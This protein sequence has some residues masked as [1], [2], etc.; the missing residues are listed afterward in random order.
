MTDAARGGDD[1]LSGGDQSDALYGDAQFMSGGTRG[2]DDRLD[3]GPG[4]DFLVGDAQVL[5]FTLQV[6][7]PEDLFGVPRIVFA[8]PQGGRDTFAGAFGGDT[9]GDFRQGEDRLEFAVP[10]VDEL[11]DLGIELEIVLAIGETNTVVTAAG[12]GTV[13][14]LGFAGTLTAADVVFA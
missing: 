5:S 1:L 3:G 8:F 7:G 10:G 2:G 14:L 12:F 6:T 9:V 11:A 4:D 13:T